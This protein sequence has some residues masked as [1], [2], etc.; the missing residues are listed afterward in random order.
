MAR[1]GGTP[2]QLTRQGVSAGGVAWRPDS[3]ALVFTAD[4]YQRDEY[5]YERSDLWV[6]DLEGQVRRLTDD[7]YQ[8]TTPAWAPDG[9]FIVFRRQMGLSMVIAAKQSNGA[10][11]DVYRVPAGGGPIENYCS[12][13]IGG[14]AHLFRVGLAGGAVEQVT[15]G[16]RRLSGFSFT[17]GF[18]RMAYALTDPT[19]PAE[20]FSARIDG[21]AEQRLTGFNDALVREVRLAGAERLRYRSKDG[22]EV[23][24][25]LVLPAGYDPARGRSPLILSI[26]GGPHGAY[27]NDFSFQFQLWATNGYGVLYTNPRGSAGY[28][29]KFLWATWGGWGNLDSDDVLAGVDYALQ[30][31]ALDPARVAVTGYSYGGFLTDWLITQTPR[32][33]HSSDQGERVLRGPL[34]EAAWGAAA[35]A[36]THHACGGRQD[37][38]ALHPRGDGLP[39]AD[40]AGRADE[41]RAQEA[42]GGSEVRA[43]SRQLPRRLDAVE[44][45][46]PV[47]S[48][49]QVVGAVPEASR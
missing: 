3:R 31:Y 21:S 14:D 23:E 41:H 49:A 46:A 26:H 25:W 40:R 8:H 2:R 42:A 24:G 20:V 36:V 16:A 34:G 15:Q 44:H 19:H 47:R 35:Q 48:G 22:T 30:R 12:A 32:R 43:V 39:G 37:A 29:E 28:G 5:T 4:A 13:G 10:V 11:V 27:G 17:S 38:H 45:G 33:R 6:V 18:D 1:E 7:G 9:R